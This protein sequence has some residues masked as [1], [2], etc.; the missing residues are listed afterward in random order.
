[1]KRFKIFRKYL[2]YIFFFFSIFDVANG[3]NLNRYYDVDKIS[4][5]F[6]GVLAFQNNEYASS[7]ESL[8][9]LKGLEDLHLS[10][11]RLYQY[12][13]INSEKFN[14]VFNFSRSLE[15]KGIDNF[16]SNLVTG[17]YFLKNN[18]IDLAKK[19]FKKLNEKNSEW[20]FQDFLTVSLD[21]W[22]SVSNLDEA[23]GINL[24]ESIPNKFKN[25]KKIQ[26][27]FIHCFY[28]SNLTSLQFKLLN[29]DEEINFSRYNFFHANYLRKT[30]KKENAFEVIESSLKLNPRSLI[31]N[32]LKIDLLNTKKSKKFTN[33]F[34][35]RNLQHVIAETFY[36]TGNALATQGAYGV[37]NFYLNLAKY[38]NSNFVSYEALYAENFYMT[39][40]LKKS[41]NIYN[42][43]KNKGSIY[44]W[45]AL[46]KIADILIEQEKKDEAFRL[47][48]NG[49]NKILNPS[50]YEI[51]DYAEFLRNNEKFSESAKKYTEVLDLIDNTHYLYP[52]ATDG[53]GISYER[54]KKWSEAEKDFLN[55]LRVSPDQAYV[56]NYLAYS[57]IEKGINI[58]KSLNMLKKANNLKKNDGYIIDSLGWALF[59]LEKYKQ[60][61]EY[62]QM[63]VTIMPSD[64]IVND[65]F[66]DSLWMNGQVLQ[67]RYYW[68][69]VLSLDKTEKEL[70]KSI[71]QK[72]ILGL[73]LS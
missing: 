22:V 54:I 17:V 47:L 68:K 2:L 3:R 55:S 28:D 11:S 5:Y 65:H 34:D 66:A 10:F 40:N 59:K 30:G 7:Y 20:S 64:P 19:Y 35:C 71:K 8:K 45:H 57:W 15:R 53:R 43:I 36:I 72:L 13:L 16:E 33:K 23:Q 63:A 49:Y 42:S 29:S 9:E 18:R 31:L 73:K 38:L 24:F 37:S 60:A 4:K 32:Q 56:L 14:E 26:V 21:N 1:M 52:K 51:Y 27:A 62:L 12:S 41:E 25:I 67:A 69:Y 44:N 6:Y 48:K 39:N 58:E 61:K 46:K 50:I 70:K